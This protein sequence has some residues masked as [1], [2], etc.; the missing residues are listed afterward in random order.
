MTTNEL[1]NQE[2]NRH[3]EIVD[4]NIEHQQAVN[5]HEKERGIAAANQNSTVARIVHISYYLFGALELLLMVRVILYL[6]GANPAN[7]FARFIDALSYPFVAVFAS[8]LENP[9][10]G[11]TGVLEVT[12]IIAMLAYAIVAS[13][14][15]RLIWLTLNRPR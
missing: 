5:L 15:G 13:L 6:I 12:T 4:R 14:V 11:T 9:T 1:R 2:L 3:E 8:L 10:V 7:G